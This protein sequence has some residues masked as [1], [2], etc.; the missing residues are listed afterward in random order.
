MDK[1]VADDLSL[2][3]AEV[4]HLVV[5]APADERAILHTAEETAKSSGKLG[6]ANDI[7]YRIQEIARGDD[8]WPRLI[9]DH[10]FYRGMAG[11]F[12]RP[13]RPLYWLLG[14]VLFAA[15]LRA[16]RAYRGR[17]KAAPDSKDLSPGA[18]EQGA[19]SPDAAGQKAAKPVVSGERAS[20]G[21]V[22]G[23]WLVFVHALEYTLTRR[24]EVP[25]EP[26]PLRRLELIVYAVLLTCFL[27]ALANTNSTLR[28]MV[29]AII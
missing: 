24:G 7:H 28:D 6:L 20:P 23:A 2:G 16:L 19:A 12:V 10:M 29:D 3:L 8:V 1:V 9:A 21:G 22:R 25:A 18:S 15:S 11:Y 5:G 13:F 4:R 17:D 14:L 26:R 27:L